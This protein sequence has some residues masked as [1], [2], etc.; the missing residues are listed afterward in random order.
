M[1]CVW[2]WSGVSC[3]YLL[4]WPL[5]CTCGAE[6]SLED[7][8]TALTIIADYL[9]DAITA[10]LLASYGLSVDVLSGP[11]GKSSSSGTTDWERALE[12]RIPCLCIGSMTGGLLL[13]SS[14]VGDSLSCIE[15]GDCVWCV[16]CVAG[17]RD[18]AICRANAPRRPDSKHND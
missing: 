16:V 15:E 9:T 5:T 11:K 13:A 7:T 17:E 10:K 8:R 2:V 12:V 1:F 3:A 6:P 18:Y 14:S 4:R